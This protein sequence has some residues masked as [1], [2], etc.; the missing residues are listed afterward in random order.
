[1]RV[2]PSSSL[3]PPPPPPPPVH[4]ARTSAATTTAHESQGRRHVFISVAP[5]PGLRRRGSYRPPRDRCNRWSSRY[6]TA[7]SKP[8]SEVMWIATSSVVA[9]PCTSKVTL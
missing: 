4:A 1:M 9:L 2:L 3:L 6:V 8:S 5:P 7:R